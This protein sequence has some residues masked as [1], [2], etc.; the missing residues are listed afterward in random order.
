MCPRCS[1]VYS[2]RPC[3][4]LPCHNRATTPQLAASPYPAKPPY[5]GAHLAAFA[6]SVAAALGSL[7]LLSPPAAP[8]LPP[9]STRV[10]FGGGGGANQGASDEATGEAGGAAVQGGAA[11]DDGKAYLKVPTMA[12][13]TRSGP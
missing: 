9:A 2:G 1:P 5:Q 10:R 12:V 4:P 3:I 7:L 13:L 11:A 8:P 6:A